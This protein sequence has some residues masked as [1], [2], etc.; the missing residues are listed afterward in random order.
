[1]T[2]PGLPGSVGKSYL[3]SPC[4]CPAFWGKH[5]YFRSRNGENVPPEMQNYPPGRP[6]SDASV[7]LWE[8]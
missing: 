1:M 6:V 3:P 8:P 4:L 5:R 2:A 7:L